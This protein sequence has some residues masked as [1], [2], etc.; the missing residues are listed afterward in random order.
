M[1]LSGEVL[2]RVREEVLL[3]SQAEAAEQ[4]GITRST[5]QRWERGESSP[6][7]YH[8]RNLYQVYGR[9]FRLL[10]VKMPFEDEL[11]AAETHDETI[12]EQKTNLTPESS[13]SNTLV[14]SPTSIVE[15]TTTTPSMHF[16]LVIADSFGEC[17]ESRDFIANNMTVHLWDLA[18]TN[19]LTYREKQHAIQ[20]A[21]KDFDTMNTSNKNYQITRRE[22]LSALAM[23]PAITLRMKPGAE[24][25]AQ[26]SQYGTILEHCAASLEACWQLYRSSD[27]SAAKLAFQCTTMYVPV[28]T[29]IANDSAQYHKEALYL[30]SQCS[31]LKTLLGWGCVGTT[32]TIPYAQHAMNLSKTSGDILLQL[33]ACSKMGWAYSAGQR[34]KQAQEIMQEGESLL[35]SY[36]RTKNTP[37]LPSYA[38]GSF[39]STY[40][41]VQAKNGLSPDRAL[42]IATDSDTGDEHTAFTVFS[43]SAQWLEAAH[44][45]CAK[46]DSIQTM[47][48]IEKRIDPETLAARPNV[49]QSERGRIETINVMTRALLQSK[50]RDMERIIS[51]WMAGM[52]G[53]KTLK[54]EQR[55]NEAI[56]NFEGMRF[57]WPDEER[58]IE[59]FPLTEHW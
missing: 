29:T 17:D 13:L 14:V 48:W 30:A 10:G 31:L 2:K 40:A 4:V 19:H 16:S 43:Q 59:L 46:G 58:I 3:L 33:S 35:Q 42:G 15:D 23:L 38:I 41:L 12:Q 50:E 8:R 45:S 6:Q 18:Y 55:Y 44:T 21:I 34:H 51:V 7:P 20:Q 49:P 22:A 11:E 56:A 28:L 53:A 24:V 39:Y 5:L 47:A 37:S 1:H 36:Q 26:P 52:K 54:N 27:A 57:I 25:I 9:G 32:A